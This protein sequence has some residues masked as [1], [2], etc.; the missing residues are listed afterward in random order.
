MKTIEN[1]LQD[2]TTIEFEV[3]IKIVEKK[4]IKDICQQLNLKQFIVDNIIKDLLKKFNVLSRTDIEKGRFD[5]RNPERKTEEKKK[6]VCDICKS[7]YKVKKSSTCNCGKYI[8]KK[9]AKNLKDS[10][11]LLCDNCIN[12]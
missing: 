3:Y 12:R 7:K 2:L 11:D 10:N 9:C 1:Y 8:C 6:V 5:T 4:K